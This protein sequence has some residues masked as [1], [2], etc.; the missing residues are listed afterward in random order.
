MSST[1]LILI[2]LF[3]SV[4]LVPIAHRFKL[5]SVLGYLIAGL[6]IGPSGLGLVKEPDS[7]FHL[8]E[9][10]VIFLMFVIGLE[11]QPRRLWVLR[12]SVFGLGLA[13]VVVT[14]SLFVGVGLWVMQWTLAQSVFLGLGLSMSS[15]ALVLKSL[16]ERHHLPLQHGRDAF[17]VLLFQDL[18]VI[19]I[20]AFLPLLSNQTAAVA[21]TSPLWIQLLVILAFVVVGRLV[22]QFVFRWASVTG[23]QEIF[24]AAAL[25][26]VVG[27]A[28]LMHMVGLSMA[29]GA[30][31]SGVLLADSEFRHELEADIEP[32]KG[33][34]LG[35]FFIAIGMGAKMSLVLEQPLSV[36][37]WV[38][39]LFSIKFLAVLFIKK[40]VRADWRNARKLALWL[41][42]G[43]EFAFVL[44]ADANGILSHEQVEFFTVVVT[45]SMLIA[46]LLFILEESVLDRKKKTE[47]HY[48][49]ITSAGTPVVIAGFGR[50]GQIVARILTSRKIPFTALEKSSEQVDFVRKF[51]NKIY[52]G[53]ANRLDLL[54]AA[55]LENA[56]LFVLAIDDIDSSLKTAETVKKHFPHVPIYARAR[57][58]FHA[59]KLLDLGVKVHYRETLL[60]S[61]KMAKDVLVEIGLSPD[62]AQETVD[63]FR[64]YDDALLQ[65]QHEIYRDEAQ[66]IQTGKQAMAD[67]ESLFEQDAQ[68]KH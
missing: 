62:L 6:A 59:Y 22:L 47:P 29:L 12:K 34:L 45:L 28:T 5:G 68:E 37:G 63:K 64:C 30:F 44:F 58:R 16:A 18:A 55:K 23:T 17:A 56:K 14:S 52:Y 46:P 39:L 8:A 25:F 4:V 9:Y 21:G 65:K 51:G 32:F 7:I 66:L 60:S 38:G 40:S 19:P 43:G 15:T 33:L 10:G 27:A 57:N 2:F 31:L 1:V 50:F 36:M 54:K 67:L 41:C 53:D 35:L 42:Q 24:T 13:Q 48:D 11:L 20:L 26:V 3:A 49:T 61:L